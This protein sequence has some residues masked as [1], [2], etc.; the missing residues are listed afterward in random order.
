M[1]QLRLAARSAELDPSPIRRI[2]TRLL[3]APFSGRE[4]AC[5]RCR[6]FFS[7][8]SAATNGV[9]GRR[10]FAPHQDRRRLGLGAVV[11]HALGPVDHVRAGRHRHGRLG[12]ELA[13]IAD[14]PGAGEHHEEAVVRM[15]MR[16]AHVARQP[17]E[18]HRVGTGLGRIA[19]Q[20][21]GAIARARVLGP[22]DVGRQLEADDLRIELDRAGAATSCSSA[23]MRRNKHRDPR[24]RRLPFGDGCPS[25]VL[26]AKASRSA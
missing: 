25:L 26:W 3:T 23:G 8:P 22:L 10:S 11:V 12:I 15:E 1:K 20:H 16:A 6:Y 13:A 5:T 21:R 24:H 18:Q 14:P 9:L 19:L 2:C 7:M 17:G 4:R